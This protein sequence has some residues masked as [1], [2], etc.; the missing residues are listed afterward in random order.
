MAI[1]HEVVEAVKRGLTKKSNC[2]KLWGGKIIDRFLVRG[3]YSSSEQCFWNCLGL[4]PLVSSWGRASLHLKFGCGLYSGR[5][6]GTRGGHPCPLS[7]GIFPGSALVFRADVSPYKA[8]LR[9]IT[10][11]KCAL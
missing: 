7:Q 8:H 1:D 3:F 6:S 5:G 11:M 10:Q 2:S 9:C 4:I